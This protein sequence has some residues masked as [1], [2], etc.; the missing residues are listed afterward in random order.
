MFGLRGPEG[1]VILGATEKNM[2]HEVLELVRREVASKKASNK[3]NGYFTSAEI[4]SSSSV[5]SLSSRVSVQDLA[6]TKNG[7]LLLKYQYFSYY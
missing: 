6:A 1:L 2:K 7:P 5:S 4:T 3:N